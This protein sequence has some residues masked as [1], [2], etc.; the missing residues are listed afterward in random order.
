MKKSQLPLEHTFKRCVISLVNRA[1]GLD[2][3]FYKS[4]LIP[5]AKEKFEDFLSSTETLD[6]FCIK[7]YIKLSIGS[8]NFFQRF[9]A[10]SGLVFDKQT[11]KDFQENEDFFDFVQP[12]DI[13]D[14]EVSFCFLFIAP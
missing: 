2:N 7:S 4:T 1:F 11:I 3:G 8:F 13:P 6:Q 10:V 12:F 5:A 14:L 9:L